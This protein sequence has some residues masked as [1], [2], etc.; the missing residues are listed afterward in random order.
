VKI[1][2]RYILTTFL[3]TFFSVFV[4][5]M[6]IFILQGIWLYIS[7][8]AGKDLDV[9]VTARFIL[10][11]MPRLIP[12]V[13]PLTILLTSIMVFGRF[14]ENYEFAAMK[15]TGISLQRAMRSLSIFIVILGIA[16]FFFSNNVI[17]WGEFKF[18]N[19][20]V[21]LKKTKPALAIVEGQFN[22]FGN[23]NI[24]IDR[25]YKRPN[26]D[27]ENLLE[28]VVIHEKSG[29]KSGNFK[30][31]KAKKGELKSSLNSNILQL[32]L[33]EGNRYEEIQSKDRQKN[34]LKPHAKTYFDTYTINIDLEALNNSDFDS[35]DQKGGYKM[36]D[37]SQLSYTIDSL[38]KKKNKSFESL[39]KTLLNRSTFLKLNEDTK[40]KD[41]IAAKNEVKDSLY[42]GNIL[43]LYDTKQRARILSLALNTANSTRQVIESNIRSVDKQNSWINKHVIALSDKYV[44]AISCIVL[45]FVGAP[46]GALIR[47]GGIGL[48]IV[49]AMVLFL[50]YY[51]L[52]IFAKNSAEKGGFSPILG[53]WLSTLIMLPLSIYLTRRATND[54]GVFQ[55]DAIIVPIKNLFRSKDNYALSESET[56]QYNYYKKY[57]FSELIAIIKNQNEFD[58]DKTPKEIALRN[59]LNRNVTLDTLK[60][61]DLAV[62]T[63]LIKAKSTLKDYLDYSKTSLVSYSIGGALLILHFIFRNNKLPELAETCLSLSIIGFIFY[64]IYFIVDAFNYSKFYKLLQQEK[65]RIHPIW[66]VLS[67]P[68]YPFKFIILKNKVKQ[69][70]FQSCIKNIK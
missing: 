1:L 56:K 63:N 34:L 58:L 67:I 40:N 69:D 24:K 28:N 2:D 66:L 46:L 48:P 16:S 4:I 35:E 3:K 33:I 11:F 44:L 13:V 36:Q 30:V 43:D 17:P 15:S 25:K 14:A 47:K 70:F 29:T 38:R 50:T 59:L 26:E 19:L 62:P 6:F 12:T 21:N 60:D 5:F 45:F 53:A 55:F 61:N 10:Y 39:S 22:D 37:I 42:T 57:E 27:E 64:A 32:E 54:K 18:H 20:R 8:L 7:E 23:I 51:F 49:I 68:L 31:V 9:S 52:G 41:T 65:K